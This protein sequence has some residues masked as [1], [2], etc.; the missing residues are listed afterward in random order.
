[1][2]YTGTFRPHRKVYLYDII[3]WSS[4]LTE[5]RT[6]IARILEVL[7]MVQLYCSIKKSKLFTAEIDFLGH[8]ISAWGIEA[9]ST[10]TW[11]GLHRH[12]LNK[13][14]NSSALYATSALSFQLLPNTQQYSHFWQRKNAM[15]SSQLGLGNTRQPSRQSRALFLVMIA[16]HQLTTRTL[17][18]IKSS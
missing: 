6:N 16:S 8:H 1:M 13:S 7:C 3:I 11:T 10:K 5:H 9:D 14:T 12:Q 4:S 18:T 2:C 15:P 17:G